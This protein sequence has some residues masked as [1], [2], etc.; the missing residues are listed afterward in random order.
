VGIA[1]YNKYTMHIQHSQKQVGNKV[2]ASVLVRESYREDGKV[3]KRTVLNISDWPAEKIAAFD[4]LLKDQALISREQLELGCGKNFGALFAFA[5]LAKHLQLPAALGSSRHGRLALMMAVLRPIKP[6]SKLG[7]VAMAR[8][9]AVEELLG[10]SSFDEDDLYGALDWVEKNQDSI[11]DALFRSRAGHCQTL[12]L[13]DVTSSY[14][15]GQQNELAKYGYNRDKKAGKKQI[16]IGL[17]K[18]EHGLPV[19]VQVYEGNT[20]DHKTVSDQIKK[21]KERFGVKRVVMIGDRGM[22]KQA[23][24]AEIGAHEWSYI[25]AL[26]KPQVEGLLEQGVIQLDLFD[27]KICQV[28]QEGRRLILRRNPKRAAETGANRQG[29]LE[30]FLALVTDANERLSRGLRADA[31]KSFQKISAAVVRYNLEKFVRLRLDKRTIEVAVDEEK[32]ESAKQLDGCYVLVT[33]LQQKDCSAETV[34]DR[35]KD[36]AQVESAFRL[37][38]SSLDVRPMWHRRADRTRG[39]VFVAML[40]VLLLEEFQRRIQNLDTTTSAAIDALNNIQLSD[41]KIGHDVVKKL[42]SQ[43]R[44]D[45]SALLNALKLRL[46]SLVKPVA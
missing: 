39:H 38:K 33:D 32:V 29:R 16:V 5:S 45:Q 28:E 1:V 27:E 44:S 46:P 12:F 43:L 8:N 41:L 3:K 21:L 15:E 4:A 34:H 13:Y 6:V 40:S 18:D 10:I 26:T 42:P 31:Q 24:I 23:Q 7:T 11:E 36:L 9:Q 30:K 37:L 20:L 35:Y 14:L 22:L 17:L 19:S 2:Y 25:T